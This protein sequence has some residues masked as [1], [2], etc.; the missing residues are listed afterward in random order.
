MTEPEW[1]GSHGDQSG[2]TTSHSSACYCYTPAG[3]P[4]TCTR[5]GNLQEDQEPA[6]EPGTCR[7]TRNLHRTLP[8]EPHQN[9]E[10]LKA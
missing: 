3:G 2:T 5:T 6:Q 1:A 4:G 8:D 10:I 7:R 9:H